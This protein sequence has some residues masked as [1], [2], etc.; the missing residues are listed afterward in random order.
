MCVF[1]FFLSL[2]SLAHERRSRTQHIVYL[3]VVEALLGPAVCLPQGPAVTSG[4]HALRQLPA[5][6]TNDSH[7][8]AVFQQAAPRLASE[9]Q[10]VTRKRHVQHFVWDAA[11]LCRWPVSCSRFQSFNGYFK[12]LAPMTIFFCLFFPLQIL[13]WKT[14]SDFGFNATVVIVQQSR[15]ELYILGF[16]VLSKTCW[17]C[18]H[19]HQLKSPQEMFV[20]LSTSTKIPV[21][22]VSQ[23]AHMTLLPQQEV[24]IGEVS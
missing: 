23:I 20:Y 22:V 3:P 11:I 1:F 16:E 4:P 21:K 2:S 17:I 15:V 13:S 7:T 10:P 5:R 14:G 9:L 24:R 12:W 19:F 6:L 8:G 18:L